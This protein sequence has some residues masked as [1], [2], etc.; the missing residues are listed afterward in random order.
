MVDDTAP[1]VGLCALKSLARLAD[2][3]QFSVE[4]LRP[5][6]QVLRRGSPAARREVLD[7]LCTSRLATYRCLEAA[8]HALL[9][10]LERSPEETFPSV[11]RAMGRLGASHA[12]FAECI[13]GDMLYRTDVEAPVQP[14]PRLDDLF[15]VCK[16]ALFLNA[17]P[18][19]R[20][21]LALLPPWTEAH[22]DVLKQQYPEILPTFCL[23]DVGGGS[24]VLLPGEDSSSVLL[25]EL[26]VPPCPEAQ[27]E[28]LSLVRAVV[29]RV[30]ALKS[31]KGGGSECL[32]CLNQCQ[33]DLATLGRSAG[34]L[35][36]WLLFLEVYVA[37]VA[38]VVCIRHSGSGGTSKALPWLGDLRSR[39]PWID[40]EE[41]DAVEQLRE[42]AL[43][44]RHSFEGHA[45]GHLECLDDLEAAA[46]ALRPAA[47][48]STTALPG[49][50]GGLSR[51][52]CLEPSL[53][54]IEA[55]IEQPATSSEEPRAYTAGFPL[56]VA[57]EARLARL[58]HGLDRIL[59][60]LEC[61]GVP[62]TLLRLLGPE[63]EALPPSDGGVPAFRLTCEVR[64]PLPNAARSTLR[65]QLVARV[66]GG[67]APLG[68]PRLLHVAGRPAADPSPA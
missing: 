28:G 63:M 35:R 51:E 40:R 68:A 44:L 9:L 54:M 42:L 38:V 15:Y 46:A 2:R 30:D 43:F 55:Q 4:Q 47:A 45:P 20:N 41:R 18:V 53:Q 25:A 50:A 13:V 57:V 10:H 64:L 65:L 61:G 32:R 26:A 59:M 7:L 36:G 23:R 27:E 14:E 60:R 39:L 1:E 12:V 48:S 17:A 58:T 49:S 3:F 22:Y 56:S 67:L 31:G 21:L 11:A 62:A 37:C 29:G 5:V 16:M 52:M 66:P 8:V 24:R 33:S 19:N 6:L 34:D